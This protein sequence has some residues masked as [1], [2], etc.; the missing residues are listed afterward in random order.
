MC[1]IVLTCLEKVE[2]G[3]APFRVLLQFAA[4]LSGYPAALFPASVTASH[5]PKIE[6]C[7]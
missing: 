1:S 6:P 7:R 5:G 4:G 2:K 3:Q